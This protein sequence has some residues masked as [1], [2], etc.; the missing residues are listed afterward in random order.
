MFEHLYEWLR[1]LSF[2]LILINVILYAI[3]ENGYRKYI[4]FFTGLVLIFMLM[5]PIFQLLGRESFVLDMEMDFL[6][7]GEINVE[8]ESEIQMKVEEIRVGDE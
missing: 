5:T 3:P 4:R 1:N 8:Q 6:E 2:Y 7:Y